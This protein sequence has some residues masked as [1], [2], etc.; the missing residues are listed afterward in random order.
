MPL[1]LDVCALSRRRERMLG[2]S[3]MR[4]MSID[5]EHNVLNLTGMSFYTDL[6]TYEIL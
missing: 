3:S 1:G 5:K 6:N 2:L 4:C